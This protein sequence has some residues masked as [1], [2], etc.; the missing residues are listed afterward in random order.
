MKESVPVFAKATGGDCAAANYSP[1]AI[2]HVY[3]SKNADVSNLSLK[4]KWWFSERN[5]NS[6]A[7][8]GTIVLV[9]H[10][11]ASAMPVI[12]LDIHVLNQIPRAALSR[13]QQDF[14]LVQV[15]YL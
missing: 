14:F 11:K 15:R 7:K 1:A 8:K 13:G 10:P 9:L 6:V 2:K 5:V 3:M 12:V 4:K